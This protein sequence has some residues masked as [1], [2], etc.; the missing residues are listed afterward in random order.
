MR[1]ASCQKGR[2]HRHDDACDC[3]KNGDF[4][5]GVEV[6][7]LWHEA[8]EQKC[9]DDRFAYVDNRKRQRRQGTQTKKDRDSHACRQTGR[10][11]RPPRSHR[12]MTEVDAEQP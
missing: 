4:A 8:I 9:A 12:V 1:N 6:T 3:D 11:S 7:S 5:Q 10:T 2:E